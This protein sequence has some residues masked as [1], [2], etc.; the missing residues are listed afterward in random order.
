[1]KLFNKEKASSGKKTSKKK[2]VL[3]IVAIILLIAIAAGVYF[4]FF[5]KEEK[6]AVTGKTTYGTLNEAIEGSGSTTPADSVTYEANGTILEWYVEAGQSVKEGDLLYVLDSSTAEETLL[7]YQLDLNELYEDLSEINEN[8]KNQKVTADFSGRIENVN[9]EAGQKVSSGTQLGKLVDDS[10]MKAVLYFGYIYEDEIKVGQTVTASF[11]EQMLT[12][13]GRVTDIKYVDYITTEGMSCF[14]VYIEVDNPGSLTEGT[15]V[16][17]WITDSNGN[18]MYAVNDAKLSFKNVKTLTA[19]ASGE[20]SKVNVVSYQ[21]VQ[22]GE[23]MYVIDA[24]SYETQKGNIQK[25]I[26]NLIEKIDDLQNQ[27]D[28]EYSRYSEIDGQVVSASRQTNRM[29]GRET[30]SITIYNQDTMQISVNFD[31]LD[32][33]YLKQGMEVTV[34]RTTSSRTITYPAYLSYLSLV[35]SSGSSGVS[36]FSGTITIESCGQLSSGVTVY[37]S[38]DTSGNSAAGAVNEETVLAPVSAL[39]SYDDGYYLIVEA[40]SKP[41]NAIEPSQVGG[42]VT[43][44]PKGYYAVPVE[45]GDYNGNYIQVLSGVDKDTTV[46]LRYRNSAPAGGDSTSLVENNGSGSDN[47]WGSGSMPDFSGGMPNF[48]GGSGSGGFSGG[49][50]GGSSSRP[51]GSGSGNMPSFGN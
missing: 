42:S 33:D 12:L 20:L 15:T 14:A 17:A 48:N 26:N 2:I 1:L 10:A 27:I 47:P 3:I 7:E 30:G 36:T 34:Y 25:Q 40:A 4:L 31:E 51:S 43:D 50:S 44:Y 22:A 45:V 32:A 29:T 13:S 37:Y 6:V 11:A 21:R 8:I 41:A 28:T 49:G 24:S 39:C 35:A 18:E 46:F 9:V 5:K 23:L 38:I 19:G 16:T